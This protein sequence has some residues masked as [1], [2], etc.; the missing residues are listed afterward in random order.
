MK[1]LQKKKIKKNNRGFTLLEI[2]VVLTIM[3]FLIAMVAPRLAGI[4]GGAVDTVCDSNQSR[5]T[6]MM[7]GYF[8]NTNRFPDK[9][10]NLVE[11]TAANT[12]QIPA[13]SDDNPDNGPETLASEFMSR[14][15]FRIHYLSTDEAAE[16]KNMGIV[17]VFNI[18]AYDGYNDDGTAFKEGYA[19]AAIDTD[20]NNVPLAATVTKAPKMEKI[21]IPTDTAATPFAVA[22]VGMGNSDST[23][24]AAGWV[25]HDD[26]KN[27]GEPDWFGR[28]VVGLGPENGLVTSGI[29][30]NAAHCPG[31]IQNADNVTY[32]DYNLVLPRLEATGARFATDAAE[33]VTAGLASF[34]LE[35]VAYDDEPVDGYVIAD[36]VDNLKYREF[37]ISEG[38]ERW[39]FATQCPE[40]HM[41]PADDEE[42]WGIDIDGNGNVN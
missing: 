17:N 13:V 26:E 41:F 36:N 23:G 22:M 19:D 27:W 25:V 2:L 14:N 5:T 18:N 6:S 20:I 31:G 4:S 30:A 38:Q 11:E 9:V 10:T 29:V 7:A 28:I 21:T 39:Q 42:F 3:G 24:A 40:G 8:E 12:Y 15:H 34:E 32:N 35:V 1:Q 37:D 16:L 33:I